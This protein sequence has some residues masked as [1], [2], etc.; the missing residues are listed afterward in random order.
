MLYSN[1]D[2]GD[3]DCNAMMNFSFVPHFRVCFAGG[4]VCP[5]GKIEKNSKKKIKTKNAILVGNRVEIK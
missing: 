3:D 4:W 1:Y 5:L 2:G